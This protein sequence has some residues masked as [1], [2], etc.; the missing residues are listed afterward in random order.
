M[1]GKIELS[2]M[3]VV[4]GFIDD[5]RTFTADPNDF[6]ANLST[7]RGFGFGFDD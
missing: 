4:F 3:A 5:L 1:E 7:A 2:Q 6:P